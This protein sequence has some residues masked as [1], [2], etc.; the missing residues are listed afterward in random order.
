M[1]K[2]IKVW[3][4][5]QSYKNLTIE[6]DFYEEWFWFKF[7]NSGLVLEINMKL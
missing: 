2:L 1:R 3:K 5:I 4:L 7:L 6:T